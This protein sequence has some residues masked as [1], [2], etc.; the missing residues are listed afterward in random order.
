LRFIKNFK[1]DSKYRYISIDLVHNTKVRKVFRRIK[2]IT[3]I[4]F[5]KL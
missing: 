5:L 4:L 1:C 3:D 2:D